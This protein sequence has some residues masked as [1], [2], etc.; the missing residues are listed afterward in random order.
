[1]TQSLPWLSFVM[2]T[3]ALIVSSVIPISIFPILREQQ[4]SWRDA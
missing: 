3:S 2:V 4:Q 1:M